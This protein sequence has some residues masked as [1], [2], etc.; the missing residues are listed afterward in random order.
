MK[1]TMVLLCAL[2]LAGCTKE[3][4]KSDIEENVRKNLGL[5]GVR[6]SSS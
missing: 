5:S 2:L 3:Y 1:K 6:V 4:K